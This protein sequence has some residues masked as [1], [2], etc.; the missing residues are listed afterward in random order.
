VSS[1]VVPKLPYNSN[2]HVLLRI[3]L[4]Q[5][6]ITI[7]GFCEHGDQWRT[8]GGL[9][10]SKPPSPEMPKFYKVEPDC[11]LSGKCLVFLFQ[12]PISLK[13]AE[14]RTPTHQ[15][16]RKEGNKILKLPVR[17]CFTL[18]TTNKLVV[19]INSI[20]YQKLRKLYYMK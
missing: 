16:V 5:D 14:F 19:I 7:L 8:E 10:G 17:N 18:A 11:K 4:T 3:L 9:G 2:L 15:D 1:R 20:K 6:R 12:H 13:I